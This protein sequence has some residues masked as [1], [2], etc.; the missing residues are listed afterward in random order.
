MN[1]T[2]E[3]KNEI[4]SIKRTQK[5][6][7][8]FLIGLLSA[9]A[10]N[11]LEQNLILK[12]LNNNFKEETIKILEKLNLKFI[13]DK[14]SIL[15]YKNQVNFAL[16]MK[17]LSHFFAGFFFG[18]GS[19]ANLNQT[20]YHLQLSSPYENIINEIL[21]KL[22]SYNLGFSLVKHNNKY[23]IFVKKREKIS[24][25]LMRILAHKSFLRFEEE[26]IERDFNNSL[27]RLTNMDICN[28]EKVAQANVIKNQ[29]YEI[30]LKN[31]LLS[32]FSVKEIKA[33]EILH[34]NLNWSMSMILEELEKNNIKTSKSSLNYWFNKLAKKVEL[35]KKGE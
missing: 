10:V 17:N 20:S 24:E 15:I 25:F 5:E 6:M 7:L 2:T 21:V 32:D 8:E 29:N 19:V 27:T 3:I 13:L 22:N 9:K 31:K 35:F 18:S 11:D 4:I 34:E 14:S 1:F 12:F 26:Y 28:L 16:P 30:A 33:F 23:V